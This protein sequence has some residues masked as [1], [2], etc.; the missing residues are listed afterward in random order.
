MY[1]YIT[2]LISVENSTHDPRNGMMRAEYIMVPF[3]W[4][5]SEKKT[6]GERWS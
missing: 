4:T 5:D 6:P 1:A 3:G 2:L